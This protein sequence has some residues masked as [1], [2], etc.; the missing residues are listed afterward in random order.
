[1]LQLRIVGPSSSQIRL[2][3][4]CRIRATK[5]WIPSIA[6]SRD[7][8]QAVVQLQVD[9]QSFFGNLFGMVNY[10]PRRQTDVPRPMSSI[11][12]RKQNS[13]RNEVARCDMSDR[14]NLRCYGTRHGASR[15][16][17]SFTGVD[18]AARPASEM[19]YVTPL[20]PL[21]LSIQPLFKS[22]AISFGLSG[23]AIAFTH[24]AS[25]R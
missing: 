18:F 9:I 7:F 16:D 2:T 12:R 21:L 3:G 20:P 10:C 25:R 23:S 8:N 5:P 11:T 4:R 1:M 14:L 6:I 24:P 22:L 13:Q 15:A 17:Y 19:R